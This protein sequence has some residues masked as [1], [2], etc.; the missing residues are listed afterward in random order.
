MADNTNLIGLLVLDFNREQLLGQN[1]DPFAA[2]RAQGRSIGTNIGGLLSGVVGGAIQGQRS[3][4]GIFKGAMAGVEQTP[5]IIRSAENDVIAGKLGITPEELEAREALR[6]KINAYKPTA[7]DPLEAQLETLAHAAKN[8][9]DPNIRG[10]IVGQMNA[11]RQQRNEM[12]KV[13]GE[14][15]DDE[16]ERAAREA[17][18]QN[19][20]I[21]GETVSALVDPTTGIA[22]VNGREYQPGEYRL[23]DLGRDDRSKPTGQRIR[24]VMTPSEQ[25]SFREGVNGTR[26][27]LRMYG[28]VMQ[29]ITD[30]VNA[31]GGAAY[32]GKAGEI[33][34][35]A[36]QWTRHINNLAK[37]FGLDN[38]FSDDTPPK[39]RG[40]SGQRRFLNDKKKE[41]KTSSKW[42]DFISLPKGV[43][44][45]SSAAQQYRAN[46]IQLAYMEARQREPANRGLSDNDI[47][48]ALVALDANSANPQI[49]LRNFSEKVINQ[50]AAFEDRLQSLPELEGL[51]QDEIATS[52]MG[53]AWRSYRN[54]YNDFLDRFGISEVSDFGRATFE[55]PKDVDVQPGEGPQTVAGQ[56]EA[57][58]IPIELDP[59]L[60]ELL[61]N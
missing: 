7:A 1:Q 52:I 42:D 58:P 35:V 37:I 45:N 22:T 36:D 57:E 18:L 20:T 28:K 46:I 40:A 12:R 21:N 32:L 15:V 34:V 17:G 16:T 27:A 39:Y 49:I 59:E 14:L 53:N 23:G 55:E 60:L 19:V 26:Q 9:S 3:G 44:P 4:A 38:P 48:N 56:G 11:L 61:G 31:D 2:Q 5:D 8:T 29:S 43:E 30:A 33:T 50:A 51:S 13:E 24:Q 6:T 54:E 10:R 41:A 47:Q 25:K